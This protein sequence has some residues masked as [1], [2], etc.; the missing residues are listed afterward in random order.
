MRKLFI[1]LTSCLLITS[2]V[3]AQD[4]QVGIGV[5]T[6]FSN[7]LTA[8]YFFRSDQAAEVLLASRWGGFYFAGLYELHSNPFGWNGF[9]AYYGAGAHYGF[10]S[11]NSNYPEKSSM[12]HNL[13]GVVGI[14]G[15][16]YNFSN[17]PFNISLDYKPAFNPL[18]TPK[19][20]IDEFGL[21]IRYVWGSR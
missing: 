1:T 9:Y 12:N 10:W 7:G 3:F 21:S 16:E 15:I 4:Y 5:R 19:F 2:A 6:P 11:S 14:A 13:I 8:K 17:I 20:W 18:N